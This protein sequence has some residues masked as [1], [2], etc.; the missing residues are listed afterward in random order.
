MLMLTVG[1][2]MFGHQRDLLGSPAWL[3]LGF[4]SA[5]VLYFMHSY[6]AFFGGLILAIYTMSLWP[7]LLKR[8]TAFPVGKVLPVAYLTFIVLVLLS[9]W[10]VAYN[11]VPG[12]TITRERTDVLLAITVLII[13]FGSRSVSS[14]GAKLKDKENVEGKH[15]KATS[16]KGSKSKR[17]S[18]VGHVFRRLS[19][20]T[21]EGSEQEWV[22]GAVHKARS[23]EVYEEEEKEYHHFH[24]KVI[25]GWFRGVVF[26]HSVPDWPSV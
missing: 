24:R 9:A 22:T 15:D 8:L 10:V 14:S 2:V 17:V 20:I 6:F 26:L 12:G 4:C 18:Y 5:M 21:E 25:Q 13:G 1:L 3:F 7:H 11:F 23:R 19:T 16:K